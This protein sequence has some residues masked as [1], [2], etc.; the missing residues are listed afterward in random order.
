MAMID[1]YEL[2][3]PTREMIYSKKWPFYF[4]ELVRRNNRYMIACYQ[5]FEQNTGLTTT[6]YNQLLDIKHIDDVEEFKP[7]LDDENWLKLQQKIFSII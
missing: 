5:K 7:F 2:Y 6:E 1:V 4:F 3:D